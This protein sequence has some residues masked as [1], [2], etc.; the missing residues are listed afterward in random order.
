VHVS[1]ELCFLVFAT[2]VFVNK[3]YLFV[4]KWYLPARRVEVELLSA[5]LVIALIVRA[6]DHPTL[7]FDIYKVF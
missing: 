1:D 6:R 3:W 2:V 5:S 4:N 7:F